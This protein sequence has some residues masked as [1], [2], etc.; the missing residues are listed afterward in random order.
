LEKLAPANPKTCQVMF[1]FR[2]PDLSAEQPAIA[3]SRFMDDLTP[4]SPIVD[5]ALKR[6]RC[7]VKAWRGRR[8]SPDEAL[9]QIGGA[10]HRV[11]RGVLEESIARF[12]KLFSEETNEDARGKIWGLLLSARRELAVLNAALSGVGALSPIPVQSQV[13]LADLPPAEPS[14]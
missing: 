14:S 9:A 8:I 5:E 2:C 13:G 7:S 12:M 3:G 1:G 4:R 10:L 11:R 6:M